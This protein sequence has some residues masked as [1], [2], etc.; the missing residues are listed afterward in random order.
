MTPPAR[1]A[2]TLAAAVVAFPTPAYADLNPSP[3]PA[4]EPDGGSH[5]YQPSPTAAPEP[6][7]QQTGPGIPAT[8]P[9]TAH[10]DPAAGRDTDPAET[11]G[12]DTTAT[13]VVLTGALIG[14]AG[15]ARVV[16]R[17]H[18]RTADIR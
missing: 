17:R 8:P 18:R 1:F 4:V 7:D 5:A 12:E 14:A 13:V 2:L 16:H 15:L 3:A 9:P 10:A 6:G 11:R